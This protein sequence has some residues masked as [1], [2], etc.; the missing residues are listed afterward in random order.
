[1]IRRVH[2]T[3]GDARVFPVS[4]GFPPHSCWQLILF[5]LWGVAT[6]FGATS[7]CADDARIRAHLLKLSH[8][9]VQVRKTGLD[10]LARTGDLRLEAVLNFYRSG[11]LYNFNDE[12]VL[13]EETIEDEDFNE[14][15]PLSD[16]LT[17][18]PLTDPQGRQ[19]LVPVEDLI[20]ISPSRAERR[21]ANNAKFFLRLSSPDEELRLS[22]AKK[23]GDPP[24]VIDALDRLREMM[25][26]DP[27]PAVRYVA[28]ESFYLIHLSE[29]LPDQTPTTKATAAQLLGEIK[30]LRA[31]PR[32]EAVL[33]ELGATVNQ[34]ADYKSL[35]IVCHTA[36]GKIRGHQKFV[37]SCENV[38]Q[39]LS[40]GS[41]LIL[42]ALGL[43][44][45]FGLMGVINMAHGELMMIGAY[46]T[47]EVQL[48]FV[49]WIESGHTS[50]AAY[51]WY[52]VVAFP[53]AFLSAAFVG[54]L[55]E[56]SVVRHLYRHPLESLLATWGIGLVL[57]QMVRLRYG[58]NIGVN[59]PQWARGS[60][61]VVQ[62][63]NLP[64]ARIFIIL[65][66][67]GSVVLVYCLMRHTTIGL[68]IRATMQSRD[69]AKSLGVNTVALDRFTF[70]FGAGLAGTAGYAWTLIGGVTP[71]MGQTNFIVDSFLVVVVGGVGKLIGVVCSGLGIGIVTKVIEPVT[72]SIWAKII[73]LIAIVAFIQFKPAGLFSPKG[74]LADA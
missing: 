2:D 63:V 66:C 35:A 38:F 60:V 36:I 44:I 43:A 16:P 51:D 3:A 67:L 22:G 49:R 24:A 55:M 15:A 7:V 27:R 46:A 12:I 57:I 54:F 59:A 13:C 65:L 4:P 52:Y 62:D 74:R 17:N 8:D 72:G 50:Q 31:L 37:S 70:A 56:L 30:S 25:K 64:Y 10:A 14:L 61:Q 9:D 11:S 58:D 40:L 1:M 6:C 47:Y 41:V 48:L 45:T 26:N 34:S 21:L 42:M 20:E 68:R 33:K 18:A 71:D 29:T 53:V 69:M 23:C 28:Q 32:L 5:G 73:L 39:G 19:L